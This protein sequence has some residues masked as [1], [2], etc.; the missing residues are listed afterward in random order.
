MTIHQRRIKP[1]ATRTPVL[2]RMDDIDN[3]FARRHPIADAA[4]GAVVL[5]AGIGGMLMMWVSAASG[6]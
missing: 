1:M 5:C 2:S 4:I 6:L 3:T